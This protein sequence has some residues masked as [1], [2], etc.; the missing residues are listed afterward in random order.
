MASTVRTTVGTE[1]YHVA[2]TNSIVIVQMVK[3]LKSTRSEQIKSIPVFR[4]ITIVRLSQKDT[5]SIPQTHMTTCT[6]LML[7]QVT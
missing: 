4:H 3:I 7:V 5:K 6:L 2:C 1:F